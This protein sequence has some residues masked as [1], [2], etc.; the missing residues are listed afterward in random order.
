[1]SELTL[2]TSL[3]QLYHKIMP[4]IIPGADLE[5]TFYK[6][7]N[8]IIAFIIFLCTLLIFKTFILQFT[9]FLNEGFM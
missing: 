6:E 9:S 1:M 3:S 8:N 7:Y 4:D 5:T 2:I